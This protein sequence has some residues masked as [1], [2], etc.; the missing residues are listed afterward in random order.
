MGTTLQ[1]FN[2]SLVIA[3]IEDLIKRLV[4]KAEQTHRVA[5]QK[6]QPQWKCI[7]E[8]SVRVDWR[9]SRLESGKIVGSLLKL[10]VRGDECLS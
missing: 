1:K 5:S 10:S 7:P 4:Q 3:R 8:G 6:F 2:C 9:R